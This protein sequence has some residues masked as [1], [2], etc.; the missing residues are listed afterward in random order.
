MGWEYRDEYKA[1]GTTGWM[2][3][4][5]SNL[6]PGKLF[7]ANQETTLPAP[8]R[9]NHI[10]YAIVGCRLLDILYR[11]SFALHAGKQIV[12]DGKTVDV[13]VSSWGRDTSVQ[14]LTVQTWYF[15][16]ESHLPVAVDFIETEP[17]RGLT[18]SSWRAQFNDFRPEGSVLTPHS[19]VTGPIGSNSQ[20]S[21][22]IEKIV[23]NTKPTTDLF[24]KK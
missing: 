12:V 21:Y 7:F 8:S 5:L 1:E 3:T 9:P 14:R 24:T 20:T 23:F 11:K 19:V 6:G 17:M 4:L 15:D 16:A 22:E 2:M 18:Y 10:P 13:V